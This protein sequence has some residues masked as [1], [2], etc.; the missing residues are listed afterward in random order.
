MRFIAEKSVFAWI[1]GFATAAIFA[2]PAASSE[3]ALADRHKPDF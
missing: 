3:P 1:A 2:L